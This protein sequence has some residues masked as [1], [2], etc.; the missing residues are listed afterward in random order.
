[1]GRTFGQP[2]SPFLQGR[3]STYSGRISVLFL[4]A[5]LGVLQ[6]FHRQSVFSTL[7]CLLLLDSYFLQTQPQCP[8]LLLKAFV[9]FTNI[10]TKNS[11]AGLCLRWFR[12]VGWFWGLISNFHLYF[13][14]FF[15]NP[16]SFLQ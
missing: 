13:F 11:L 8:R 16:D 4:T 6:N 7:S 15:N 9:S 14:F 12:C 1:M 2:P 10:S 5:F 3:I